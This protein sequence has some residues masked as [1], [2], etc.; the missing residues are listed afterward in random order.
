MRRT[1]VTGVGVV[2]PGGATRDR[3]WENITAGR[4]AT[5]PITFFDPSGFRWSNVRRAVE[6]WW[7]SGGAFDPT[8]LGAVLRA[9]Y[10][11]SFETLDDDAPPHPAA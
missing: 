9:G 6:G 3:F 1:V 4:T 8:V 7:L 5:G 2:A 10:D 11:R